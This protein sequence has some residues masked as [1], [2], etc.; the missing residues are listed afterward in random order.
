MVY[1]EAVG[2]MQLMMALLELSRGN[3]ESVVK[4]QRVG[5]AWDARRTHAREGRKLFTGKLPAWVKV[6]AIHE[7]SFTL[8]LDPGRAKTI[9][10]IFEMTAA[11]QGPIRIV[12]QFQ[13]EKGPA[14]GSSGTSRG[15]VGEPSHV[16]VM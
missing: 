16:S 9:R 14:F 13:K 15:L 4:S 3:S 2:P 6:E 1:D 7:D 5:A 12:R 8:T 10:R 11:G